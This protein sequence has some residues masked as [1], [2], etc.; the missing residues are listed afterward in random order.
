M[1]DQNASYKQELDAKEQELSR[2]LQELGSS[3]RNATALKAQLAK[4]RQAGSPQQTETV[5]TRD[6][7]DGSDEYDAIEDLYNAAIKHLKRT[8]SWMIKGELGLRIQAWRNNKWAE[9]E[10]A[11][12]RKREQHKLIRNHQGLKQV[13]RMLYW[14]TKGELGLSLEL[15][16]SNR[17]DD[18]ALEVARSS[19]EVADEQG[20]LIIEVKLLQDKAQ[21]MKMNAAL[22]QLKQI[23]YWMVKGELGSSVESWRA[24]RSRCFNCTL[25]SPFTIQYK[26]LFQLYL[27]HSPS[28][29]RICFNSFFTNSHSLANLSANLGTHSVCCICVQV[30]G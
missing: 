7:A 16:R 25:F 10:E 18:Q 20:R 9:Q 13:R 8:L 21:D 1:Q 12:S 30:E 29:T 6:T 2:L 11:L 17:L 26:D 28:N 15:W 23:L 4:S 22:R 27:H 5:S 3:K 24:N 19:Y 14:T